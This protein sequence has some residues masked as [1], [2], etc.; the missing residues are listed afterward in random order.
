MVPQDW[1]FHIF[2]GVGTETRSVVTHNINECIQQN[3]FGGC[4]MMA[5][6][7]MSPKVVK[8]RVDF[9]GLGSWCWMRVSSGTKKTRIVIAYQPCSF[10]QSAGTM[11]KD[12]QF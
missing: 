11:V 8:S 9:T 1:Q 10:G 2:G 4:A 12:Q 5:M 3:Q 6:G 7:T